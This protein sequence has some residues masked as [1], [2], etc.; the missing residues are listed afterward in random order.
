MQRL[1]YGAE[2]AANTKQILSNEA[3]KPKYYFGSLRSHETGTQRV[4]TF[5][6]NRWLSSRINYSPALDAVESFS[7]DDWLTERDLVHE[8][9]AESHSPVPAE[10]NE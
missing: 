4:I 3:S 8:E 5:W 7:A 6:M 10:V 9:A 1:V 2:L